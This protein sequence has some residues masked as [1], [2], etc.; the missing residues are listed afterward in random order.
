MLSDLI[1][2]FRADAAGGSSGP[3]GAEDARLAFAALMVRVARADDLFDSGERAAILAE[4]RARHRMTPDAA[5][6]L[7]AEAEEA[8]AKAPDTVRFTRILKQV[9]PYEARADL[10]ESLWVVALEDG[11]RHHM[12]DALLRQVA[13]LLGVSDKD[14][15]L[16]RQAAQARRKAPK[17]GTPGSVG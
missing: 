13:P 16:A 12:E 15:G 4:L 10:V 8:E 5:G 3:L 17:G 14:S 11:E 2:L 9:T 7:L 1:A 6:A